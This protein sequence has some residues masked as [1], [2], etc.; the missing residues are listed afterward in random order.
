MSQGRVGW[1]SEAPVL[2]MPQPRL[3]PGHPL[4]FSEG[5]RD[6]YHSGVSGGCSCP[7]SRISP[8]SLTCTSSLLTLHTALHSGI[9][10][11]ASLWGA[12]SKW[13]Q[14]RLSW[15]RSQIPGA[16]I[17][18]FEELLGEGETEEHAPMD[19]HLGR[20]EMGQG[21]QSRWECTGV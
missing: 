18:A 6:H 13:L 20:E 12:P 11:S 15:D 19:G 10:H 17:S 16:K 7:G 1:G 5:K 4:A 3:L 2:R 14:V 8:Q 21:G 9:N